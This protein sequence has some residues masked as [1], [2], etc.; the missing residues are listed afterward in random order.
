MDK[1]KHHNLTARFALDTSSELLNEFEDLLQKVAED[2][3]LVAVKPEIDRLRQSWE[4]EISELKGSF[5]KAQDVICGIEQTVVNGQKSA[6]SINDTTTVILTELTE[7]KNIANIFEKKSEDFALNTAQALDKLGAA[8]R[9]VDD[10]I[11][12]VKTLGVQFADQLHLVAAEL[13]ENR[14][15]AEQA[16]AALLETGN[17]FKKMLTL[18]HNQI[19]NLSAKNLKET[20]VLN[21]Q[22]VE[23]GHSID[24]T[25]VILQTTTQLLKDLNKPVAIGLNQ[26]QLIVALVILQTI[27]IGVFLV[28]MIWP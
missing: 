11:V 28:P 3:S 1:I 20:E 8:I 16:S 15:T 19:T 23:M 12:S 26:R 5:K 24:K 25:A 18:I 4:S 2:V 6:D 27:T 10:A 13:N 17:R 14:K 7:F 21:H 9:E 22:A